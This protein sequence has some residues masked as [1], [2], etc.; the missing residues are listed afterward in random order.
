[1]SE[2]IKTLGIIKHYKSLKKK[3]P[4]I[5]II[6]IVLI[7]LVIGILVYFW[8][9]ENK[10]DV[11]SD[12]LG[13][14]PG[15]GPE[16]ELNY[17]ID[18]YLIEID[19]YRSKYENDKSDINKQLLEDKIRQCMSKYSEYA[20][21][22]AKEMNEIKLKAELDKIDETERELDE[23]IKKL[24]AQKEAAENNKDLLQVQLL[25]KEREI[26][27]KLE[28]VKQEKEKLQALKDEEDRKAREDP[29][30]NYEILE[31]RYYGSCGGPPPHYWP[32]GCM[33]PRADDP[34]SDRFT[35]SNRVPVQDLKTENEC[36]ELC[37]RSMVVAGNPQKCK[38]YSFKFADHPIASERGRYRRGS[39]YLS[40][41]GQHSPITEDIDSEKEFWI[42]RK[43]KI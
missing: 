3:N 2:K 16:Y 27:E 32:L 13:P 31:G 25:E 22:G 36:A 9:K 42:T 35:T 38:G 23:K 8:R 19:S 17:E 14:G 41:Y 33:V 18:K 15:P 21:R 34:Q 29:K 5:D 7:I 4:L 39:C 28:L 12:D 11:S 10:K 40:W 20:C 24:N 26:A 6:L 37:N 43:K 1:M 30:Y